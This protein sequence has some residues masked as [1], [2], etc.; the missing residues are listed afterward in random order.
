MRYVVRTGRRHGCG[1]CAP[2]VAALRP[3]LAHAP[4]VVRMLDLYYAGRVALT[5]PK[6]VLTVR[7]E[8]RSADPSTTVEALG[9]AAWKSRIIHSTRWSST[10]PRPED[11]DSTS[12]TLEFKAD[13]A[14]YP[15]KWG[16]RPTG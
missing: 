13:A 7:V 4:G 5:R 3:Q 12:R 9:N 16:K 2:E 10:T 8:T 1:K 6:S 14:A 11:K 15:R